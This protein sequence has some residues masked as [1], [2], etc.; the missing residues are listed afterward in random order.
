MNLGTLPASYGRDSSSIASLLWANTN[1]SASLL[2]LA[3]KKSRFP[4]HWGQ[5]PRMQTMDYR[6]L[7]GGYGM[8]SSTLAGWIQANLDKDAA[9]LLDLA[10]LKSRFPEHWGQPPMMQTRDLRT[11]PGGYGKGSSTLARWI[12]ANLDKDTSAKILMI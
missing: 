4:E 10:S 6:T 3:S 12:Q 8:G 7:P 9:S 2:D 11:L 5:P 1:Y